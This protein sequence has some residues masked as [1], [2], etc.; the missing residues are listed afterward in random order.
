MQS[1]L[2]D[3]KERLQGVAELIQGSD[4]LAAYL[5]EETP[6]LYKTL[7]DTYEPYIGEI[8]QEVADN[9][10]LQ[11]PELEQVLLNPF[12]EGLFQPRILGY[13]VL[14]GEI[15]D[16]IKY[17]RPQEPFK[18]I[19]LAIANSTNF[20]AIRQRIGQT[21]Q[22]GFAL[23]S[24]IWIANLL[25]KIENKKVKLFLQSM[26]HD[27]FR[28]LE[29]RR[30][31]MV[32]YKKQFTHYNFLYTRFP[33][34]IG[35]LKIEATSV[36]NFLLNRIS[37]QS[38]HDSYID[39]IHKLIAQK[40]FYKEPEFIEIISI[41]ANF[42][43]LNQTETQHLANAL[44]SC[45]YEN[46]QFNN[47]YFNFLKS[48][49]RSGINFGAE[50]DRK[51]NALLN[52]NE[53]DDLIKFYSL[54]DTIHQKGFVHEDALDAVNAFY[55]QYEGMSIINE[56]LRLAILQM[57]HKVVDNLTE[58]EYHYFF[59]LQKTISGYINIFGNSAFNL[60]TEGMC[61]NYVKKLLGFYKDKRSKEYQEI[62]R[63]VSSGFTE[64][65]F[66]TEK[67]LIDL[68]KIKRK[69]KEVV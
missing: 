60:E 41:I 36:K 53:G 51:F 10:P 11:L 46:E 33:E 34:T 44:N 22:L 13:S 37:F 27:R 29:E 52:K 19:L 43:T 6:E 38:K 62:K 55:A 54:L 8:Y 63:A 1:L 58:P 23:S 30:N 20:D 47:L 68:F 5:E 14:R 9:H 45:R 61:M 67:E 32:R 31:L 42:I 56:C 65:E 15:N 35:E 26:I 21:V 18:Q 66:L 4:E 25:E 12:F 39:E 57:L 64:L 24:D 16:Q 69:K 3:Y 50:A 40:E 59:E 2:Q 28:E 7:Q 17:M 48:G 49:Y